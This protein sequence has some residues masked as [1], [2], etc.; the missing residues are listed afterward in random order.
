MAYKYC[1]RND[2]LIGMYQ[3]FVSNEFEQIQSTAELQL[4][5]ESKIFRLFG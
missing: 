3:C 4:G 2:C 1:N 5:G